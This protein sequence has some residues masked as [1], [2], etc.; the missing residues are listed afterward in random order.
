[1]KVTNDL[2]KERI[3]KLLIRLAVPSIVSQLVN[4]L[5]NMVDRIFIGKTA[6]GDIAM[7]GLGIA[8]PIITI[9][10]AFAQLF[11]SGG[12]PLSAIK[13]GEEDKE[14]AER[15]MTTSFIALLTSGALLTIFVLIFRQ[16]ILTLFGANAQTMDYALPYVTIYAFGTIFVQ[17]ALG[18]NAYINCQGFATIGMKTIIIG[19]GLNIILDPIFIFVFDMGVSGAALATVLSQTV[20]GIW[21][22]CFLFGEKSIL[23]IRKEHLRIKP[24]ILFAIMALGISPFIMQ[25][26]E[27]LVQISFNTQLLK[28]GGNVAVSSITVMYSLMTFVTLPITG[29]AQG[30]APIVSFNYGARHFDRV[31]KTIRLTIG[32]CAVFSISMSLLIMIFSRQFGS[33]FLGEG[34]ILD[35]TE[36]ALRIFLAGTTIFGIQIACQNMFMALGQAKISLLMALLRKVIVLVPLIYIMPMFMQDQVNAVILAEP[37]ADIIAAISTSSCF[38]VFYKKRL[39][40]D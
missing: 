34:E 22:L 25:S 1:M 21:V 7:A 32:S 10:A 31:K 5:Y 40:P 39:V 11:G 36:R 17:I 13:M 3:G 2:G 19:A 4:L 16:S 15:I 28:F 8:L 37:I 6:D 14:G 29:L 38:F 23:K 35:F 33:I 26:T 30:A 12:A 9:V 24:K 18:M 27:S 20:S